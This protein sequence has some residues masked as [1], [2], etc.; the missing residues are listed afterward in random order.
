MLKYLRNNA[1]DLSKMKEQAL[2][3]FNFDQLENFIEY[4]DF[5]GN[6]YFTTF[7]NEF[8]ERTKSFTSTLQNQQ[9]FESAGDF[10]SSGRT[11]EQAE[12]RYQEICTQRTVWTQDVK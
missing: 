12:T 8:V 4:E 5:L 7:V 6:S 9:A 1:Y 2:E 10:Y 11:F 3:D